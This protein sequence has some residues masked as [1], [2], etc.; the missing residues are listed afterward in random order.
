MKYKETWLNLAKKQRVNINDPIVDMNLLQNGETAVIKLYQRRAF[1]KEISTLEN[2]KTISGQGT[3]FKLDSFLD[4][5]GVLRVSGR[6]NKA[7]LNYRLKHP[8]LL[9]KEGHINHAI[10]RDHHEKIAHADWGMTINEIRNH[11]Y[12]IINCTS[13]VKSV[14]S[15]CVECRKLHGKICQQKMGNLPAVRLLEEPP[16]TYC[17]IDMFDP[18]LVKDGRKIQKR[19]GAMFTCF[20]S[21]AVHIET[22]SNLATDIF[23][24][25]IRR[26]ISRRGNVRMI[27]RDNVTNFVG[28]CIKLK[29]AFCEMDE[30]RINDFVI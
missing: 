4:N 1:Q 24:Q 16:F 17:G 6:I 23:I 12:W 8:V 13:T 9:P 25:A 30:K 29:K 19:Y 26:L 18:F 27:R 21:R 14:I 22:T 20:S 5:D 7:N 2:G 11:E 15:K 3:I 28:A 10:I